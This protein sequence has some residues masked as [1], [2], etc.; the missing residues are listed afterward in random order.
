VLIIGSPSR[1]SDSTASNRDKSIGKSEDGL[2]IIEP[3]EAVIVARVFE[4][5]LGGYTPSQIAVRLNED[6]IKTYYGKDWRAHGIINMLQQEKYRGDA[7]LQKTYMENFL[8]KRRTRV[9]DNQRVQTLVEN[10]HPPIIDRDTF[11][12]VQAEIQRR[13]VKGSGGRSKGMYSCQYAFSTMIRCGECGTLFR[14]HAQSYKGITHRTWACQ[15]RIGDAK[16][17]KIKPLRE[18][19]IEQAFV[20]ALN[21]LIGNRDELVEEIMQAAATVITDQ[22]Q[23]DYDRKM[24]ELH[25]AREEMLEIQK[26]AKLQTAN[27]RE[28]MKILVKTIT[29]LMEETKFIAGL[30]ESKKLARHRLDEIRIAL[31]K[32]ML[33]SFDEAVFKAL[34]TGITVHAD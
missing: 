1:L 28:R 15:Q 29:R 7:I 11:D 17:C 33:D 12:R 31:E 19:D 3:T 27:G 10:S 14:R 9:D 16:T 4:E 8:S 18:V 26:P 20:R 2:L 25:D 6:G 13:K 23:A 32:D 5:Y 24:Q 30:I 34:V 21:R 22:D